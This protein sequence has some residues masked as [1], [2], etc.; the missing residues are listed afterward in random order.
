MWS[1]QL[2][3]S[4]VVSFFFVL[5]SFSRWLFLL[6]SFPWFLPFL[7]EIPR[8]EVM[9]RNLLS[10]VWVLVVVWDFGIGLVVKFRAAWNCFHSAWNGQQ[11]VPSNREIASQLPRGFVVE[12]PSDEGRMASASARVDC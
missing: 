1:C 11:D 7:Q 12:N 3:F 9:W 6:E 2:S 8:L 5:C 4:A 10:P